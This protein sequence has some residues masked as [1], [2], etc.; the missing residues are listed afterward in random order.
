MISR[1]TKVKYKIVYHIIYSTPVLLDISFSHKWRWVCM[2]TCVGEGMSTN[3][4]KTRSLLSLL[5]Q[6]L[7][8][9][10]RET[11]SFFVD[12]IVASVSS[13]IS[14]D[15]ILVINWCPSRFDFVR[16][17]SPTTAQRPV[18]GRSEV[19]VT[20]IAL[21]NHLRVLCYLSL[22]AILC[23]YILL[24]DWNTIPFD[25]SASSATAS[26]GWQ[27]SLRTQRS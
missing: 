19:E 23:V 3:E 27:R 10:W 9:V 15:Y 4:N 21:F 25:T 5:V 20:A 26:S 2:A 13:G 8:S 11:L 6:S 12:V 1:Y 18:N 22:M 16:L 24:I 7:L 14:S 17:R